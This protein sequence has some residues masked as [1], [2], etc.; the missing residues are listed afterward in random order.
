M[1]FP[2]LLPHHLDKILGLRP[3]FLCKLSMVPR[4]RAEPKDQEEPRAGDPG[5]LQ[6]NRG[7]HLLGVMAFC[8]VVSRPVFTGSLERISQWM[9]APITVPLEFTALTFLPSR[10]SQSLLSAEG[11]AFLHIR[12]YSG[13]SQPWVPEAQHQGPSL[14]GFFSPRLGVF[15]VTGSCICSPFLISLLGFRWQQR[16]A[17]GQQHSGGSLG[18]TFVC[19]S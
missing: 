5:L 14:G 9:V 13:S 19:A 4:G 3:S 17:Q 18:T 8:L 15:S 12:S 16:R 1:G 10:Q 7:C 6:G 11:L 2:F